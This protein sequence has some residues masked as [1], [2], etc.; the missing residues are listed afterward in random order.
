MKWVFNKGR[1]YTIFFLLA[2]AFIL[3]YG[4]LYIRSNSDLSKEEKLCEVLELD[5]DSIDCIALKH[6]YSLR[7]AETPT[8]INDLLNVLNQNITFYRKSNETSDGEPDWQI[9][10]FTNDGKYMKIGI[11]ENTVKFKKG[12]TTYI[13][14]GTFDISLL[15]NLPKVENITKFWNDKSSYVYK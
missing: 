15:E 11:S 7:V 5:S 12:N 2:V 10:F 4:F 9:Y 3:C 13:Y 1:K 8:E 6:F 14:H